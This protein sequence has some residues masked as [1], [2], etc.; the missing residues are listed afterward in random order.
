MSLFSLFFKE[1]SCT[2][3]W[4][5][6]LWNIHRLL[7]EET[8]F[9]NYYQY[10]RFIF[11]N[12]TEK[13]F[14]SWPY[15]DRFY[16]GKPIAWVSHNWAHLSIKSLSKNWGNRRSFSKLL[17]SVWKIEEFTNS[18]SIFLCNPY[19]LLLHHINKLHIE[20]PCRFWALYHHEHWKWYL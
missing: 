13:M 12:W 6:G 8:W 18:I 19:H 20:I 14:F 17:K 2:L 11:Y 5:Q 1:L 9:V 4:L 15:Q 10:W 16:L 7:F 3:K